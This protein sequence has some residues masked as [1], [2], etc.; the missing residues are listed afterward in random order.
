MLQEEWIPGDHVS[1]FAPTKHGKTHLVLK[2]LAP[3]WPED[4]PWLTVDVK[5]DDPR[6]VEWGHPFT[7][8]LPA[9]FF[10]NRMKHQRFRLVVPE[11]I[12]QI[13]EAREWVILALKTAR[14]EKGWIVHLNEVRALSDKA[15]PNLD[16]APRLEQLWLRG[17]PHITVIAETQRGAW[18]PGSMYDQPIHTYIG[19]FTDGRMRDRVAEMGGDTDNLIRAIGQLQ[20]HEFLY[21]NRDTHLLQIVK[22]PA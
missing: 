4:Y 15:P 17:Q 7:K 21:V 5:G 19:G 18:V 1:L 9:R 13:K 20:K 6:L 12:E 11:A 8:K 16:L 14:R 22:A 10:R 2:G 3:I